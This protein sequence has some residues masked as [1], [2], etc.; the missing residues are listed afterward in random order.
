MKVES[1]GGVGYGK[2]IESVRGEG[3]IGEGVG[4]GDDVHVTKVQQ[5]L[6]YVLGHGIL[7]K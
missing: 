6:R 4:A 3:L 2:A 1:T 5:E 7:R